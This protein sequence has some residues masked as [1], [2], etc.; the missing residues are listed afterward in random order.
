MFCRPLKADKGKE[1]GGKETGTATVFR[2]K[3]TGTATVFRIVNTK[4]SVLFFDSR[5]VRGPAPEPP[6]FFEA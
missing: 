2:G 6:K 5:V 1:T 4:R 3:E